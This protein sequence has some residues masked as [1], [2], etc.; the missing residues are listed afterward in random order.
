MFVIYNRLIIFIFK[1]KPL[2]Y[3]V[4]IIIFVKSYNMFL[5]FLF[6]LYFA[7]NLYF[8][9]P[10]NYLFYFHIDLLGGYTYIRHLLKT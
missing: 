8:V 9:K 6:I 7:N 10:E 4:Q 3:V 1:S 2:Y 5:L